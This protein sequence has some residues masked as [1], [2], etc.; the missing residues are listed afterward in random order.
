MK[1]LMIGIAGA[2]G[3]GKSTFCDVLLRE[4][5]D[6]RVKVIRT[7]NYFKS[8]LPK[9]ISPISQIEYE[10]FNHPESIDYNKLIT[11]LNIINESEDGAELIILEGIMILYFEDIRNMLELKIFIDLDSDERMYR[12]IKRNMKLWGLSMDDVANYFLQAA[13]YRER[14]YI[15]P[16]KIFADIILNG[17][18]LESTPKEVIISWIK[19]QIIQRRS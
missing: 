5:S 13:K 4:L 3:S 2:S 1:P 19:N 9:I 17:N 7:D 6:L 11:D 8:N 10:D 16:T 12:R 18:N 15:L 14:E